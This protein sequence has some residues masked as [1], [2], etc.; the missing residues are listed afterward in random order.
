MKHKYTDEEIQ[1]IA[2]EVFGGPNTDSGSCLDTLVLYRNCP[3]WSGQSRNRYFLLKSALDKLPE[4]PPLIEF[5]REISEW[6]ATTFPHQTPASKVAHLTDEV[7]ELSDNPGD[8]EEMADCFILLL[9]LAEMGG[10]DLLEEAQKKMAKN[11]LRIWGAPDARGVCHHVKPEPQPPTVDGKTPGQV[12]FDAFIN[13]SDSWEAA[14]S[15]VLA[16]FG[17]AGLEAAI[18][19]MESVPWKELDLEWDNAPGGYENA[20][21]AVR[22]RLIAA[23]REGQP[24][25]IATLAKNQVSLTPEQATVVEQVFQEGVFGKPIPST[26]TAHGKPWNVHVPG[27]ERPCEDVRIDYLMTGEEGRGAQASTY[28][29]YAGELRWN[30][31]DSAG[32]IIGW[33]Y[34][35]EPTP[36]EPVN[37]WTPAVGDVVILKSGGPKMSTVKAAPE[38][39]FWCNWF[40]GA[41]RHEGCFPAATLQPA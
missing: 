14:T 8:G 13:G 19:R 24:L 41:E 6:A 4:P 21:N 18:A 22:A 23:A 1:A 38:L 32:D 5:Q 35:D 7:N 15:A 29:A 36:A 17:G 16:A 11:K 3:N 9:N 12:A 28:P 2:D 31:Q 34:A 33:R 27:D 39:H 37:P 40:D 25:P 20:I 26:F 30:K 10:F